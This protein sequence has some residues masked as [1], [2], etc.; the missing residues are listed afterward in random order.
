MKTK[1]FNQISSV[2]LVVALACTLAAGM[3][4]ENGVTARETSISA[5]NAV[6]M[7]YDGSRSLD[8]DK[9]WKFVLV[10]PAGI[11]DPTG[12]YENAPDPAYEDSSWRTLDV[13][14]DWSIELLP[15]TGSGSGTSG[16]TG[17]LQGGLGWYRKSFTLPPSMAGKRISIE[18]D[19]VY[20]DS[21]IYANG[22]LLGNHPYGYTGFSFDFT[23]LAYT[24]GVTPNVI[25]VKVQNRL[26]SS[27]WYSGSGIYR[28][29]RLVVTNDIHVA[30]WGTFVTTPDLENTI[31]QGF[32]DVH[33]KTDVANESG[34]PASVDLVSRILDS[35]G[36]VVAEDT[37]NASLEAQG[38]TYEQDL[39]VDDPALWSFDSPDLYTLVSD[40]VVGGNVVDTYTTNFGIRYSRIDPNEGFSLNG[41]YAKIQGVNLHHDLGALGS[42]VNYNGLVRQI[43]I[44]KEMGVNA[45]RTSH[46]PPAPE[47]VKAAQEMGIVLMV[48]AFDTWQRRKTT[49]DYAR[50][51]DEYSDA[52][53]QEM[54]NA[55]K[56]SPS[57]IIWSIGNEIR[58]QNLETAQ[59]L[60]DD[61]KEIDTSRPVVWGH[62]GYRSVPSDGSTNDQIAMILDGIGLNYNT[63]G[64]VDALHEKYPDKFWFESE[65]SS[66]TS[67]RGYYQDPSLLNTS[68][69]YT[70]GRREASSYDNNM[71]SWTMPGEYG[72]KK[73]R[74]REFFMGEFLWSGFDYIGEP[75]PFNVFPVKSSHFGAVDTAGFPKDLF[76]LFQSQ[77]T[78]E[79]MV[80]LV[81]MSWTDWKP[82]EGVEVWAYANVDTVEL[83]LNGNSL[84]VRTFDHKVTVYGKEYLETTEPTFDDKNVTGGPYPGSYTSPNGSAGKLHLTWQVPFEPGQ[85]V[86]VAM[87]DGQEVARDELNT[88]G[89]PYTLRLTPDKKVISADG[90]GLSY[91]MVEVVDENG[92][93]VP[94]AE[95][96]I[97]FEVTGGTLAGVDNG[98]EESAEGYKTPYRTAFHGKALAIV[99]ST[100]SP[101][102][103]TIKATSSGLLPAT[104]TVYG[105]D[106]LGGSELV[107]LEPVYVRTRLSE[108]PALP[109]T[110]QGIYAD[111]TQQAL[112]VRW[113]NFAKGLNAKY[114]IYTIKGQVA[115]TSLKAEAVITVYGPVAIESFSTVVP[116]GTAPGLPATVRLVY[117]DGVDRFVPVVWDPID[118][119]VYAEAGQF[120]VYGTVAEA[121]IQ[122]EANVR[123]TADYVADQ[124]IALSSSPLRPSADASF[125]GPG[126]G[127]FFR[128]PTTPDLMLDGTTDSSGWSNF[129][130]KGST[131]L[132]P[133]V[134]AARPS[135]WVSVSWPNPHTT[136]NLMAYFT[137]TS[138]RALPA[139]L[140]VSYWDGVS[141]VPVQNLSISWAGE[142]NQPTSVNFDPVATTAFRLDM[143]SSA[144]YS[145]D[146]GFLQIAELQVIGTEVAYNTTA[147][148][149][150]L[151]I[152]GQTIDGFDSQTTFYTVLTG[153]KMPEITATAADNGRLAIV[154]PLTLPGTATITVTSEEGFDQQTYYID[155]ILDD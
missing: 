138:N 107:A 6:N 14:H 95:N 1:R 51:F 48:E 44:L 101:G 106:E 149:T 78:S 126:T 31:Q 32:A 82:G 142:S 3:L 35:A 145:S 122:A 52:D 43:S 74:D 100:G 67:T 76:Y 91:V 26:P 62:D 60:V 99:Q 115:G 87:K 89:A 29:V 140:E 112:P 131:A 22:Q 86:A 28:N 108:P 65:S 103:I 66:S 73:D 90:K 93:M 53:I 47:L 80:H 4:P 135:E 120:T 98:R 92:V 123:V 68:E 117:N 42:A 132:L 56:N 24:D 83:F 11:T 59:R 34:E 97:N 152:N 88:A 39:Q 33:V 144:P 102:P 114:G 134:S 16:G 7:S 148:L 104:T 49:Y 40:L 9:D 13:P 15:V 146:T 141:F 63:A 20:M 30:R 94:S 109:E 110:V 111:N 25:A 113:N 46:N 77:W 96:L 85:L 139:S 118:P 12:E 125:S 124:N 5:P 133:T 155:L 41:Q 64:S 136:G 128:I 75:T 69:N 105:V 72:L 23:D 79:P 21:Y 54:V 38:A 147:A 18:F 45:I 119:A 61:I 2:M 55:F 151:R 84:G 58:G 129:F 121:D 10:N 130:S 81:P 116:V 36:N 57:V 153:K 154:P 37:A 50:F 70:P 27:R 127:F 150:D 17:Y 137:T 143:T 8:F 19:G 71:A